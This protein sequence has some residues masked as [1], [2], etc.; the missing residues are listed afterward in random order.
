MKKLRITGV[1]G[2]I[3][4]EYLVN[5]DGDSFNLDLTIPLFLPVVNVSLLE[6]GKK[7]TKRIREIMR[8]VKAMVE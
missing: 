4:G 5:V 2:V 6:V 3:I 8:R 7:E 1:D